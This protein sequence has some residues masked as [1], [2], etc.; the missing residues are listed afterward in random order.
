MADTAAQQP[1]K[2]PTKPIKNKSPAS[3][4]APEA[5][6]PEKTDDSVNMPSRVDEASS[7]VADSETAETNGHTEIPNTEN[8]KAETA[9]QASNAEDE[10]EEAIQ[11]GSVDKEGKVVD[12]EGNVIGKV[13]GENA[14]QFNGSVVD[15]QGDI[16]DDEGNVIGQANLEEAAEGAESEVG[17]KA[18]IPSEIGS[19]GDPV[20]SEVGSK[21]EE[22]ASKAGDAAPEKPELSGPF[23][24]QDNGEVTNA[25]G[26]PVGKL[27]DGTPQDLVGTSI[28]DIDS[29]GNLV[30]GSGSIVGK[31]NIGEEADAAASEV[32]SKLDD[33]DAKLDE[34]ASQVGSKVEDPE[35]ELDETSSKVDEETSDKLE[36]SESKVDEAGEKLDDAGEPAE[37]VVDLSTLTGKKLNKAGKVV[38]EKG[39]P[40]GTLI[41]GDAKKLAGKTVGKDGQ[42]FDDAGNV[43]GK[44]ELLPESERPDA[45]SSPFEDFPDSVIDSKGNVIYN[46][47]II[48][49]LT[50]GD[51]KELDGKKVD[52]DGDVLDKNGNVIGKAERTEEEEPASEPEPEVVDLSELEGKKV[53]KSGNIVDD[54]GKL[55]GK[56]VTGDASKLI[57]RK[58]DEEGKIYSDTGKVIGTAE[59][60]SADDRDAA[61]E[62][63]FE[64]FPGATV[65]KAGKIVYEDTVVGQLIEGDAKKL[66]GKSVDA[67]GEIIDKVGNVIGKAERWEE[68]E[69]E[70]EPEPEAIDLSSLAGKRVNK[71]GNVVDS[72]GD[73]YGRIV[74]GDPK[75]L[76]GKM[77]DKDGQIWDDG[78]KVIGK[79]EL[80]PESERA[81]QKEGP[82]TGFEGL[83][84]TK[85]GKVKDA[86]GA[87][88]GRLTSGDG[89]VLYGKSVDDDGD[90][91]DKNGNTL[92]VAERW[93]EEEKVKSKH[94]AAGRKVNKK[95]EVVDENGDTIA[96]LTDGA[97]TKCVGNEI[98][99]DGDVVDGKGTTIGHVTILEDIPEPVPEESEEEIAQRKQAEDDKKLAKN[100]AGVV[101]Q[102][103]ESIKPILKMITDAIDEAN[104]K[105][106]E[107]LDEQKLVD[108]VKPLLEQGGA[109]LQECN[110]AI[111]AMDPDGRIQANAKHKSAAKEASPEEYHLAD[112]LKEL[113]TNVQGTIDS[114]KKKIA[115]LPHAKKE[116]NPLWGLLAEPLGQ[117]LAAV[118]LLLAGVLGLVGKLLSGLGLGGLLDNLLG[119]LG[120]KGILKGLGLGMVTE[121][122]TGKK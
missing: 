29:Q 117:I 64:D 121:S 78:G 104:A 16:L 50:E 56:L 46:E 48:G 28:K 12:T 41:E 55:F 21:V 115:G 8:G 119:G 76:A 102:S 35:A 14:S 7:Q 34:S 114:A 97:L 73:I 82:F 58:C 20:P 18:P 90:V 68:P 27:V 42:V 75:K 110:G 92:G 45:L 80:V 39:Q 112:L 19:K 61:K 2:T 91:L 47:R 54:D 109:V 37:D 108:T 23:G 13:N 79:A 3:D 40:W 99:D 36:D 59:L 38:D 1:P 101:E 10:E 116:L 44:V 51:A 118:G 87:I 93:E 88:V 57:G 74:D 107:E 100:L 69:D 113:T 26:I 66:L 30:K 4:K 67:D 32:G 25:S 98:D 105:P 63:P 43:M 17:S 94:P 5:S 22:S 86:S 49:K 83:T 106:K 70:P 96:K 85:D 9:E 60:L 84:V 77:C 65:D 62:S 24:V 122:L 95:G 81:G 103:I 31:V 89:K 71:V 11:A 53:N 111:R 120:L 72:N 52:A 15:Q 6:L 33:P